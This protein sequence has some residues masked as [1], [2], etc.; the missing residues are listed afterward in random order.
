MSEV[1][2]TSGIRI[3]VKFF[4]NS[5]SKSKRADNSLVT[6][7]LGKVGFIDKSWKPKE[8]EPTPQK[9]DFWKVE[10][11]REVAPGKNTGCFILKPLCRV[12]PPKLIKLVPG[13]YDEEEHDSLLIIRPKQP[14]DCIITLNQRQKKY[15]AWLVVL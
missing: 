9:G 4:E 11:E 2:E 12:D 10:I 7:T 5:N 6:R 15:Y 14:G 13:M 3:I 8:G 1:F